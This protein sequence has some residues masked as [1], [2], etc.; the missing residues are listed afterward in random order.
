MQCWICFGDQAL[1]SF[2]PCSCK[3]S[4]FV[5]QTCLQ[6]YLN[7]KVEKSLKNNTLDPL[8]VTCPNCRDRLGY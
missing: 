3:G 8:D 2:K 1:T 4:L 6:S 5:H 7:K